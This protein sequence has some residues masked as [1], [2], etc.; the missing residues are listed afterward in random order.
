MLV[1]SVS[2]LFVDAIES[3]GSCSALLLICLVYLQNTKWCWWHRRGQGSNTLLHQIHA[4]HCVQWISDNSKHTKHTCQVVGYQCDL[5]F[6]LLTI[7]DLE[8]YRLEFS[9]PRWIDTLVK[10][11]S[12]F[13]Y[14]SSTMQEKP[15][16]VDIDRWVSRGEGTCELSILFISMNLISLSICS[17]ATPT[18]PTLFVRLKTS[19]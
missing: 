1:P 18:P 11:C 4:N 13:P 5:Q 9:K 10:T 14:S 17:H 15:P 16:H 3:F 7:L 2:G 8:C 6:L 12:H 19:G